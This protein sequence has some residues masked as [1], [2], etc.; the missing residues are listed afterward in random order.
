MQTA[1]KPGAETAKTAALRLKGWEKAYPM[2][3][4]I[5]AFEKI[6]QKLPEDQQDAR[7]IL[8]LI[9]DTSAACE[10]A[11]L[12]MQA[13][14][15]GEPVPTVDD[16]KKAEMRELENIR[17]MCLLAMLQGFGIESKNIDEDVDEALM[18]KE[19]NAEKGG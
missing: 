16:I 5:D 7:H 4:S 6:A 11:C 19:K 2:R 8:A 13:A 9:G 17:R 15:D 12:L 10:I 14:A 3:L 18:Q 1:N